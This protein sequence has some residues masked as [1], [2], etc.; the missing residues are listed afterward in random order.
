MKLSPNVVS[1]AGLAAVIAG[2]IVAAQ[3]SPPSRNMLAAQAQTTQAAVE[4]VRRSPAPQTRDEFEDVWTKTV[5]AAKARHIQPHTVDVGVEEV[6]VS[7]ANVTS[8]IDYIT[9]P[10]TTIVFRHVCVATVLPVTELDCT[11]DKGETWHV[12][13]R[14]NGNWVQSGN[15]NLPWTN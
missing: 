7:W 5:S 4:P 8:V 15:T 3:N 9:N 6:S 12:H 14:S 1:F 2:L 11:S 13:V 10:G